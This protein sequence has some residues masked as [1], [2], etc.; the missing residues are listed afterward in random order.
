LN[1]TTGYITGMCRRPFEPRPRRDET[2]DPCL[3]DWDV[4]NFYWDE[5]FKIQDETLQFLRS[6]SRPWSSR[7]SRESRE[8][9][10]LAETFSVTYGE[11]HW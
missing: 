7:E 6:W 8:L 5:K 2:R 11:T 10:H 3:R 9:Q 4:Q 1:N